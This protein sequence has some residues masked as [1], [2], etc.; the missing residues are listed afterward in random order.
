MIPLTPTPLPPGTPVF[1]IPAG[2]SIWAS[3]DYAIQTWNLIGDWQ[4][5]IQGIAI[6]VFVAAGLFI[7]WRFMSQMTRKDSEE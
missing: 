3:T 4:V 1:Q 5:V 6:V 2:Y 7:V